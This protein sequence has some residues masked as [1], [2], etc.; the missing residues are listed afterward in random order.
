MLRGVAAGTREPTRGAG[1]ATAREGITGGDGDITPAATAGAAEAEDTRGGGAPAAT[2][3]AAKVEDACRCGAPA[4]TAGAAAAEDARGGGIPEATAG[5]AEAEDT[6]GGNTPAATA[7]A[8]EAEDVHGG[9]VHVHAPAPVATAAEG[10]PL[11]CFHILAP[12]VANLRE[13]R[14][15]GA[16]IHIP[17]LVAAAVAEGVSFLAFLLSL[18]RRQILETL[19]E[20]ALPFAFLLPWQQWQQ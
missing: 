19:G 3:E 4:A 12:T 5:V 1:G 18:Q 2:A 7:G 11:P 9:S 17:T 16:P 8:A 20:K 15:E 13:A 10:V 6:C 14:G